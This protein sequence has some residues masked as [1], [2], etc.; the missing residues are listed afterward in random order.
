MLKLIRAVSLII[1]ACQILAAAPAD[2]AWLNATA[3]VVSHDG[4]TLYIC[5]ATAEEIAFFD[6]ASGRVTSTVSL[7]AQPSGLALSADGSRLYITCASPSSHVYMLDTVRRQVVRTLP[8][9]HTAMA[10]VLT[11]DG[12]TLFVCNRFDNDVS[13]FDLAHKKQVKRITVEREPVAADVTTDGKYLLVANHLPKG[14]ADANFLAAVVSVIDVATRLVIKEIQLPNGSGSLHDIRVSP[15]GKYAVVTHLVARYTRLPTR[16][17]G[18]WMHG[19]AI[20]IIDLAKMGVV[21]TVLL[22]D[23]YSGAGNPWGLAWS[24]DS[25]TLVVTHAGTHEV[26]VIDFPGLIDRLSL[27]APPDPVNGPDST[28]ADGQAGQEKYPSFFVGPR[29]RIKLPDGDLGPRAAVVSGDKIYVANYFSDTITRIDFGKTPHPKAESIPLGPKREMNIVR[30]GEFYFHD[31]DLCYQGWQ[32]CSS[33]HP[34]DARVDGFNWDLLNDGIGNPKN[35]RSL[36]LAHK[37]PPSMSLGVRENAEAAVRAGIQHMLFTEQPEE[38]ATAIDEYLKSLEPVPSPYLKE[39]Q[40]SES[41]Q[42]GKLLFTKAGCV[43]C[44]PPPLYTDLYSHDVG[45]CASFD[46]PSDRFY[47]PTLVELWRTA[48]YLHDGSAAT[49]RDILTTCN[50]HDH[51][52]KTSA[53]SPGELDDLCNFLLSL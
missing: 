14:R 19:N 39:G 28:A 45:T 2:T 4:A 11:R 10:P 31:A 22:D 41:A 32:S 29:E 21:H 12:R 23:A 40:L 44:H 13:V 8:A 20:T 35:T 43:G 36:L 34:G 46:K 24:A 17:T 7:G 50:H 9:G 6:I 53:L 49:V 5:C 30:K 42:R 33:C 38:V 26:S 3:L 18:G 1:A 48:P 47:P 15:D 16:P 25:K 27:P 52:G 37:T 51:H